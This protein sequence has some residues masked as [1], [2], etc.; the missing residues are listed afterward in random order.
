MDSFTMTIGGA[1]VESERLL[2][3]DNPATGQTAFQVP[4]C[5]REQLEAA[6]DSAQKAFAG[7]RGDAAQRR[8]VLYA[9]AA[10][11]EENAG[12]LGR[13]QTIEQGM[14]LALSVEAARHAAATF[15]YYADLEIPRTRVKDDE[16]ERIDVVRRPL[17]VNLAITA[18]NGPVIQ[19]VNN[20]AP[21]LWTGN[22]VVLKP[23]PFTPAASLA[24]GAV[25]RDIVPPGVVNVVSGADP[26]GQWAVEHPV[27]RSVSFTGSVATG[28]RV[29]QTASGDLKRVLLEL[30]GNDPLIVLDDVDPEEFA[31]R[32]FPIAF[33][34]SGQICQ[35]PKRIYVPDKLHDEIAGALA[36]RARAVRV[37]DGMETGT[38]LGPITTA[39]QF[40]RVKELVA[41]ALAG[42][43]TALA[44]GHPVDRPGYFFETTI[45]TNLTDGTRIVDEEQFGPALPV[46]R[47]FGEADVI[48]RANATSYGL[49]ASVW[50]ADPDRAQLIA[51]QLES[52]NAWVNTHGVRTNAAPFGGT[53]WS[54][55]GHKNGLWTLDSLTD[56]QTVWRSKAP[57]P[58]R[59]S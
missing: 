25:L 24:L 13:I 28:K 3:V 49:G 9:C 39:P 54:G 58:G 21:P 12:E 34:N 46:I 55:L 51:E 45:L 59:S 17:G 32:L 23:S 48:A 29:N 57:V 6:M 8:A 15:R 4:D 22:T 31:A 7:W 40:E 11:V 38:E 42:G 5:G 33:R 27:P 37:G 41:D 2:D 47:Y 35:A 10:A 52:G 14:P 19:A 44:G 56:V 43:A 30:G 53:K 16:R 18:W 50:S 1:A 20:I 36:A 26:L